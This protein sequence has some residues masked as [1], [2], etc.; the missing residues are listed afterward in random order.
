VNI[1]VVNLKGGV[2]KTITS[3]HLA[4]NLGRL[5]PTLLVDADP[6]GSAASWAA[7]APDL[8]FTTIALGVPTLGSR[9]P[10]ETAGFA[11]VVIDTPP[12]DT[13]IV[14]AAVQ[15]CQAVLLP[16]QPTLQDLNRLRPTL[17]LIVGAGNDPELVVVMTRVRSGTRSVR[18]AREVLTNLGLQVL[19]TEIPQLEGYVWGFGAVPPE[20]HRYGAVA[21]ELM[22]VL[23]IPT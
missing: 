3:V 1:A 20:G 15:F 17:E 9:L 8:P 11:H 18:E 4:A 10:R 5:A 14:R 2:G 23:R 21:D 16:V 19:D 22:A 12:G 6:Q 13:V 7:L